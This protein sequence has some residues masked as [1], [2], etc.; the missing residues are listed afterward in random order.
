MRSTNSRTIKALV[1]T[2]AY[3]FVAC[4]ADALLLTEF[5]KLPVNEQG[6]MYVT[7]VNELRDRLWSEFDAKGNRKTAKVLQAQREYANFI[8]D[9]FA[10]KDERRT[11]INF[12]RLDK[13]MYSEYILNPNG[14]LEAAL[15]KY[16]KAALDE[17]IAAD[18]RMKR[19]D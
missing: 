9:F 1:L 5:Y 8:A 19:S 10:L 7:K 14:H 3:I 11:R 4:R 18:A 13:F 6:N 16:T 15:L 12:I 2:C 17:K